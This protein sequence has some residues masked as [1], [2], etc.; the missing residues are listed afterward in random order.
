MLWEKL[1]ELFQGNSGP[2]V[3]IEPVSYKDGLL[4]FKSEQPLKL[5]RSRLAAP[6]K[7]GYFEVKVDILSLDE[8][9]GFYRGKIIENETFSLDAM[10]MERRKEFRLD[11]KIVVSSSEVHGHKAVTEDISLNGARILTTGPLNKGDYIGLK[12]HFNDPAVGDLPLRAEVMWCS[13]TRK[14]KHH[15]GMRFLMMEKPDREKIKRYIQ[16]QVALGM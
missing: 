4:L 2:P 9:G 14:G 6:S 12:F 1:K 11:A 5:V 8:E 13:P 3:V 7:L 15:A 10:K 16:N